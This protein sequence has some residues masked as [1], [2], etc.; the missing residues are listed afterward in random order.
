MLLYKHHGIKPIVLI[1][2]Y[3]VPVAKAA[4]NE[5]YKDM[6]SVIRL[7]LGN[8]LKTNLYLGRAVLTG[9]LRIAKESIFTGLNNFKTYSVLDTGKKYISGGIGFTKEET[10]GVLNYYGLSDYYEEVKNNYDGYYFGNVHMYC[11]WDVMSFCED[12][13]EKLGENNNQ[14]H[15]FNY[16]IN[17]SS[18][19]AFEEFMGS[20]KPDDVDKMQTLVDGGSITTPVR[21]SLSYGDLKKH[22]ITDF[23]T[24]LLYTGYLTFNP[25]KTVYPKIDLFEGNKDEKE[26]NKPEIYEILY[27]LY[28]PNLEIRNCFKTKIMDY[29]SNNQKMKDYTSDFVNGMFSGDG[30][31]VENSLNR[32]LAKY[33]SIRDFSTKAPRE[34]YYHGFI[35]GLLINSGSLIE[36]QKSSFESGDGYVDLIVRLKEDSEVIAIL[37]L[38]QTPKEKEDRGKIAV[39]AVEQIIRKNYAEQF[40]SNSDISAV[41]IYGICFCKKRCSVECKKLK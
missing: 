35:N 40:I 8:A 16:W 4:H 39:E 2:E 19:D 31:K 12:S 23:W 21:D 28:I 18:N 32:L 38:K 41:L 34:N 17:T 6:I 30:E 29:F 1:D 11:P 33:V 37:E 13:L 36:E 14:I 10:E 27:N 5:Y 7:F 22:N 15:A 24:L 3:D 26:E 25:E 20:L 9:C